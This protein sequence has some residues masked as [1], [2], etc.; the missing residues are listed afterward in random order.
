MADPSPAERA[1]LSDSK[2]LRLFLSKNDQEAFRTLI[3]RHAPLVLGVCRR[4]THSDHDADDAFQA[5]FLVLARSAHEI[6][7]QE[8]LS[9]WLYGV[10]FRVCQ[11]LRREAAARPTVECM[12]AASNDRDPLDELLVRHDEIIADEEVNAL[13]DSLRLPLVLRYLAGKSNTEA[14]KELGISVAALEGRLK[15]GKQRLRLRLLRRGVT[16]AVVVAALKASRVA[17]NEVP[18]ALVH[19][20]T[21]LCTT[22]AGATLPALT[23]DPSLSTHIALQELHAMN[24]LLVSKPLAL[25]LSTGAVFMLAIATPMAFSQG[26]AAPAAG[27]VELQ[28]SAA[29]DESLGD[30]PAT[31]VGA[32]YSRDTE[33]TADNNTPARQSGSRYGYE[34]TPFAPTPHTA[35]RATSNESQLPPTIVDL[36]PRSPGEIQI[37]S[38]LASPLSSTGLDFAETALEEVVD[39]LRAEYSMEIQL[40]AR[41]LDEIGI[42]ADEPVTVYV[43]NVRLES[44]LNIM[45]TEHDLTFRVKDEVLWITTEDEAMSEMEV[46]VYPNLGLKTTEEMI[47]SMI[48]PGTWVANKTGEGDIR[49]LGNDRLVIRQTYAIHREINALLSQLQATMEE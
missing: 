23:S 13:P 39:F 22:A 40:D 35:L 20:T 47:T 43:Q 37:E 31:P 21:E 10:A 36:K 19:T 17:A 14:A 38:A 49:S 34:A 46:R 9:A 41:A 27:Q 25:A 15:R 6:R 18:A 30:E 5:T 26:E 8:S 4:G 3:E 11:R 32:T 45:L 24:A 7:R 12:D 2:L 1:E 29:E 42:G 33:T 28:S 16:L 48:A 44:A